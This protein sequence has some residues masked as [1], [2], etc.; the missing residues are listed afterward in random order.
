MVPIDRYQ[1]LREMC[2]V[3]DRANDTLFLSLEQKR[4][5]V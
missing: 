1:T 5:N 2:F 3:Y 4:G